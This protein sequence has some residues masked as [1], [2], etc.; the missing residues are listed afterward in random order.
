MESSVNTTSIL[1][2]IWEVPQEFRD[3]LGKKVGRQRAMHADGHL[4]LVLH[5][6][7]TPQDSER[8]GRLFWRQPDGQWHSNGLGDGPGALQKHLNHYA[9]RVEQIEQSEEQAASSDDYFN[10]LEQLA[11]LHRATR[12]LHQVLQDARQ[13]VSDDR[14]IINMRDRAYEVERVAELLYTGAQHALE[15]TVARRA[16]D[17]AKSSRQMA[18][19]A[20]RLNMLAG[21][22][23]PIA[24]LCAIFGVN[25]EHKLED[26]PGP[27][28]FLLLVIVGLIAGAVLTVFLQSPKTD[29]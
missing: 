2:A 28:P 22:F 21:F 1:P 11:P 13:L 24:T 6:P 27:L 14:D 4:L 9:D 19:A 3:R 23:F 7:P 16:E 26:L 25:L 5:D 15:Y 29:K 12:N 18:V 8:K 17:E 20:H 10:V